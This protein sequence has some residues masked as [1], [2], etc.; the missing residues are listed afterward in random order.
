MAALMTSVIENGSKVSEYILVCKNMGIK[1]LPP[2][3]NEGDEAFSVSGD[4][5]RYA[6]SAV[7]SVGRAV[8]DDI[9]REREENGKFRD[10][11]DFIKRNIDVINKRTVENFIKC[12]ALDCFEG[13]RHQHMAVYAS[14]IDHITSEK[15]S[16]IEGQMSLFDIVDEDNKDQFEASLPNVAEFDKEMLLEF[17][18]ETLGIYISGH[19]LD[20]YEQLLRKNITRMSVDFMYQEDEGQT[21]V[22]DGELVTVGGIIT[23][24]R[25]VYTKKGEAM[26]RFVIE[27]LTGIIKAIAFP[28]VYRKFNEL[29]KDDS[30]VF[31]KGRAQ[32]Q[33]QKDGELIVET[34]S[35][36][37]DL[38]RKLWIKFAD[39]DSYSL[40]ASKLSG[41]LTDTGKDEAIIYI[42]NTKQMKKSPT[43]VDDTLVKKLK[44]M[45]GEENIRL[46]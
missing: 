15:K 4:S 40:S 8:I 19:P 29:I 44:E 35:G 42:E 46:V 41:L 10:I 34:V 14:I 45:F 26:A 43:S 20:E 21:R 18:K 39:M 11:N 12:G 25:L 33:E 28:S 38:P 37:D 2:D 13:N 17:E 3:V 23:D 24:K 6:L 5:I 30:K 27:D 22:T 16:G 9:V 1:L 7:K 31:V 32:V 36:I